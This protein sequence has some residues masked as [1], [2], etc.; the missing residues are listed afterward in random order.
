MSYIVWCLGLYNSLSTY[1]KKASAFT[2]KVYSAVYSVMNATTY[3]FFDGI[4]HAFPAVAVKVVANGAATPRWIYTPETQT[5]N[6]WPAEGSVYD[7]HSLPILSMEILYG[8][9]V[10]YDLT[11]F[12]EGVRVNVITGNK[13]YPSIAHI[14]NAWTIS[15]KVV[16]DPGLKVRYINM[17]ADTEETD[18]HSLALL[19]QAVEKVD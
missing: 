17:E 16:L 13:Y 10:M 14:V 11:E 12:A 19:R 3:I 9:T 6:E 15:S 4:V 1:Y 5:F 8:E 2:E 7:W 18:L